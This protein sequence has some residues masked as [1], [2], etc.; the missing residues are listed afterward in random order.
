MPCYGMRT[1]TQT[2]EGIKDIN[3]LASAMNE[4]GIA[5]RV[6][7]NRIDFSGVPQGTGEWIEGSYSNERLTIK[8]GGRLD[9]EMLKK[10]TAVANLKKQVAKNNAD[11]YKATKL[12]LIKK[13]EFS[14]AVQRKK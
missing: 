9:L 11:R 8:G 3:L 2:L 12:T 7:A 5:T 6:I 4:M 14:Y 10:Y 1:T 13:G